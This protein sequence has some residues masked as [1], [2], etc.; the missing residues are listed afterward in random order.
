MT[1]PMADQ[2]RARWWKPWTWPKPQTSTWLVLVA[3]SNLVSTAIFV[4]AATDASNEAGKTARAENC[5][6][7]IDAFDA[8]TNALA[9]VAGSDPDTVAEFRAA[10]EPELQECH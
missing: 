5:A 6:N 1:A 9:Q 2:P 7:V 4:L 10:Y 8:Y 3:L